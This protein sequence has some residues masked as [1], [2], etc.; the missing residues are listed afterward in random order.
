MSEPL[1]PIPYGFCSTFWHF[2]RQPWGLTVQAIA[3]LRR[4][5][6]L[7]SQGYGY[8]ADCVGRAIDGHLL[9]H[10]AC[11]STA[12]QQAWFASNTFRPCYQLV[13]GFAPEDTTSSQAKRPGRQQRFMSGA[14]GSREISSVLPFLPGGVVD[15][16]G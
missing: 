6:K 9:G 13:Y 4:A 3:Y 16:F 10:R 1:K 2:C 11:R 7:L 12:N 14:V 15:A 8:V 5:P